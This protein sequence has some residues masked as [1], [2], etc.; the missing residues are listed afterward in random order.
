MF[1]SKKILLLLG[2]LALV[3]LICGVLELSAAPRKHIIVIDPAHGGQ[4]T[5]IKLT[6]KVNEKDITLAVALALRKELAKENNLEIIL[7]R[8]SDKEVSLEDR[9]KNVAKIKPDF[10]ISLHTN[11]GFGK[12]ASGFE[13]YYQEFNKDVIKEKKKA[14]GDARQEKNKY[15]NDSVRLA[16]IIQEN[17]NILFPRKGRGLRRADLPVT[18]DLFVPVVVVEMGFA[19]NPEDKKKLLSLNTQTEIANALGKSIKSFYR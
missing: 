14:K 5:G 9:E 11:A 6:D 17:L 3:F 15:L 8:D 12:S 10:V 19:T 16:R 18:E 13:I 4:D 7:T 2:I 1:D